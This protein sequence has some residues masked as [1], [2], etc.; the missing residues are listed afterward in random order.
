MGEYSIFKDFTKRWYCLDHDNKKEYHY[1]SNLEKHDKVSSIRYVLMI[2][3]LKREREIYWMSD[4]ETK[5][6]IDFVIHPIENGFINSE[7][8]IEKRR[9][10]E[11]ISNIWVQSYNISEKNKSK[12][13]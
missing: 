4:V 7:K 13:N 1:E 12:K 8:A 2:G 10:S 11:M 6:H 9:R 5:N 3:F